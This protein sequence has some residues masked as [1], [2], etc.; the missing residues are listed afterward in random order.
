VFDN[1]SAEHVLA[2]EVYNDCWDEASILAEV[3]E[4]SYRDM[5]CF[6]VLGMISFSSSY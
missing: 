2:I 1:W 5:R 6:P 3:L 4:L